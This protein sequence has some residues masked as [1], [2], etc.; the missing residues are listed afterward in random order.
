MPWSGRC[1]LQSALRVPQGDVL[2]P[3]CTALLLTAGPADVEETTGGECWS[4]GFTHTLMLIPFPR[5]L[6][7]EKHRLFQVSS[8]PS[9]LFCVCGSKASCSHVC[10]CFVPRQAYCSPS[11]LSG[12]L[13]VPCLLCRHRQHPVARPFAASIL[14]LE[15]PHASQPSLASPSHLIQGR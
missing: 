11:C 3:I 14:W 8:P 12:A 5:Q 10:C 7:G 4:C 6:G 13:P 9:C 1:C 15:K 2:L